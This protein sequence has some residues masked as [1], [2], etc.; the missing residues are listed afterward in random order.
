MVSLF[1]HEPKG[2]EGRDLLRVIRGVRRRWRLKVALRGVAVV[3]AAGLVALATSA[4]G[5]DHF[6]YSTGAIA[7][8][9]VLAWTAFVALAIRFLVLPL[10]VRLPD[11]RVALYIEEHD[12]SL[13]AALLS[14]I[15]LE[16][17]GEARSEESP[18]LV[19]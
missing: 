16:R 13:Q 15:A 14:A 2:R 17:R 6:R 5:L 7:A 10:A 19:E 18:A 12:P 11:E 8:F 1:E 9:R 3:I 4:W